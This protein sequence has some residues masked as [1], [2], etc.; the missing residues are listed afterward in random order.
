MDAPLRKGTVSASATGE[1]VS[2]VPLDRNAPAWGHARAFGSWC[3]GS[4]VYCYADYAMVHQIDPVSPRNTRIHLTW[5]VH[6]DAPDEE[7]DTASLTHVWHMTTKQDVELIERTQA[8]LQSR[9]YVPG[10][11][12]VTHEPYIH[13]SL[14]TYLARMAG[15]GRIAELVSGG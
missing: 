10:P 2:A 11:L 5:F 6:R 8:G 1:P 7:V 9:R 3:A 12:S 14:T 13:S 15:D 4:V